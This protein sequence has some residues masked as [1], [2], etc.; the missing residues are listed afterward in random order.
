[1]IK[2]L[3]I[4]DEPLAREAI[5][6]YIEKMPDLELA[7]ECENALQAGACLR[8]QQ[9]D[10]IF[11]DIEMPEIDGISFLQISNNLPGVILTTAYRNYAVEA[12]ELDVI[13]Y[14]LKPISFERFVS[15]VNKYYDRTGKTAGSGN[16]IKKDAVE[17]L[18][19]KADRKTYKIDISKICYIESL[20]D[21]VK[22]VCS[23][24]SIVTHDSLSN[25]E[26]LL[27]KYGFI[28]IHNSFIVTADKIKSYNAESVFLE[29][30]ELPISR[31]Y[32]K[33]VLSILEKH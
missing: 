29:N 28:R 15:A 1:M 11:L 12:F 16:E 32:K 25:F 9:M 27:N 23:D 24:E 26:T 31:T 5:R 22:I 13:D 30:K 20:K 18:N 17:Y 21:Y 33:T 3:I 6:A 4:D 10:L 8:K 14:L 19:V 7:G 2:C